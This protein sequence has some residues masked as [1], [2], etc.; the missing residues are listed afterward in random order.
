MKKITVR[1][2]VLMAMI[3]KVKGVVVEHPT[4]PVLSNIKIEVTGPR[5]VVT[6]SDLVVTL[7]DEVEVINLG[8]NDTYSYLLPFKYFSDV[9]ATLTDEE[10]T[11][12]LNDKKKT[13]PLL[14][15]STAADNFKINC[16]PAADYPEMP[17]Y[18]EH[19]S[20]GVSADFMNTLH[21]AMATTG[22]DPKKEV[23]QHVW[24]RIE[25]S[26]LTVA[27]SDLYVAYE[28]TFA[29]ETTTNKDLIL[30]KKI[31]Q[32]TKSFKDATMSWSD[33]HVFFAAGRSVIIGTLY[34]M[35]IPNYKAIIPG[36]LP[37]LTVNTEALRL[38][39]KK[40]ALSGT[41]AT[42]QMK[43]ATDAIVME[44]VDILYNN[45]IRVVFPANYSGDC[46][47]IMLT[48]SR[49]LTLLGQINYTTISLAVIAYN[50]AVVLSSDSDDTYRAII[51]PN[52]NNKK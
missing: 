39:M 25:P 32:N 47:T 49:L 27:S 10:V 5:M 3:K 22:M 43:G 36:N 38:A 34:D 18:A 16:R 45:E 13:A 19:N 20:V 30:D 52:T 40:L 46:E 1:V 21:L 28:K 6:G 11:L 4:P 7:I 37:N 12:E 29:A 35:Q 33:T 48:P 42:W 14:T 41:W 50:Q 15:L 26:K 8:N 17:V 9:C 2:A 44:A 51:M 24:L 23:V 31:I